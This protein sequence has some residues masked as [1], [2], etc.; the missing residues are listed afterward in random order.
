VLFISVV[1]YGL[2]LSIFVPVFSFDGLPALSYF[3][4]QSNILVVFFTAYIMIAPRNTRFRTIARGSVLLSI[5]VT[6]LV[7]HIILVPYYPEF[8]AGGVTFRHHITHTIAPLGFFLDWFLFDTRG[9]IKAG[10]IKYWLV[11]PLLY[12]LF[13]TIR[14]LAV[15]A[16]PYF[17]MDLNLFS[18]FTVL[19]RFIALSIF[20]I[21]LGLLIAFIDAR[22]PAKAAVV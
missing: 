19:S 22:R 7:F 10:D 20:F 9:L 3:T 5:A 12:W 17:F 21:L 11:Y 6:G 1:L 18:P 14:G 13:S 8:F 16:Y 15:G 4:V 2:Y